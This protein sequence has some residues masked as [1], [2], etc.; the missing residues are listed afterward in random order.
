MIP[1]TFTPQGLFDFVVAHLRKQGVKS[2]CD[3]A[4]LYRGPGGLKCA[5]GCVIRDDE[6]EGWMEGGAIEQVVSGAETPAS[7]RLRLGPHLHA[8]SLLQQVHDKYDARAW[9]QRLAE[10]ATLSGLVYTP[11]VSP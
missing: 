6:Y 8:L 1:D 5:A 10:A 7:L 4:C 2:R 9:E 3:L 11:P